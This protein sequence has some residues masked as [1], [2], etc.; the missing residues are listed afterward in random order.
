MSALFK[1]SL[2]L[3]CLLACSCFPPGEGLDAPLDRV[4][5]PVGVALSADGRQ[6]F[7]AN[8][9]FDLQYNG[10]S[11]QAFDAERI[12]SIVPLSCSSTADCAARPGTVCDDT[13]GDRNGGTPSFWCL[14]PDSAPCE[15]LGEQPAYARSKVPGRCRHIDPARPGDGA[16]SLITGSV[17]IGAF[18]TDLLVTN[19]AAAAAGE[20]TARL[21]VPV[22][23]DSTL[24]WIDLHADG[25][26]DCGQRRNDG[27]CDDRHRSGDD[28]DLEHTRDDLT[29]PAEPYGIAAT[30][31]GRAVVVTHQTEGKVSVFGNSWTDGTNLEWVTGD[32][33]TR[34]IGVAAV[35][36]AAAVKLARAQAES[37]TDPALRE[38]S[39]YAPGF[40]VTYRNAAEVRLIRYFDDANSSPPRPF[41][42]Q[43]GSAEI[44]VNSVSWDS[45]G[46]AVDDSAR[47][48]CEATCNPEDLSC[49]V[50]CL[51]TPLDVFVANRTPAS[52]LVGKTRV[53]EAGT[54]L[55]ELPE[56]Y[57]SIPLPFGPS[58][59]VIGTIRNELGEL[60]RRVFVLCFD[61]RRIV[62][63]DP[64]RRREEAWIDTGSGPHSLAI[65]AQNALAYVA[66]F[67]DSYIGV[68]DL[69]RKHSRSYGRII[70][71]IGKPTE[72]RASK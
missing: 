40:L 30:A 2:F 55:E 54:Q 20:P 26:L 69:D 59:V 50:T 29:S 11:V 8:S 38:L 71:N 4:Y 37:A 10:G 32:M 7:V 63:Y 21:F 24:H 57:D 49:L 34:P 18:A 39:R 51:E 46:I 68:I 56:F 19:N 48:Q 67:T 47:R 61:A 70:A 65:D 25:S 22:R 36:P 5:F 28:P 23:G 35:P 43:S 9:D 16:G 17:G 13:P 66:H 60:E 41:L 64:D 52:L 45:R 27:N 72:P 14:P 6:L 33:P 1:N 15:Q 12:R 58:R 44:R 53:G 42:E 62:I 3:S 31:D